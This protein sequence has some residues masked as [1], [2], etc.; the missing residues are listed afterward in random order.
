LLLYLLGKG[1]QVLR[2]RTGREGLP[3]EGLRLPR[4]QDRRRRRPADGADGLPPRAGRGGV[5]DPAGGPDESRYSLGRVGVFPRWLHHINPRTQTPDRA[6]FVQAF[7][8]LFF[9]LLYGFLFGP[10]LG[11]GLFGLMFTIALMIIYSMTNVS[12]FA[13]Y[14]KKHR[15][16][17]NIF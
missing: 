5:L 8:S 2:W 9:A 7:I 6:I 14:Y 11:F 15:D 1:Y 4:D 12:C 10:F 3:R 16:E 17:F 13:I